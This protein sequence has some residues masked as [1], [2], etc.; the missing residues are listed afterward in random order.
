[1]QSGSPIEEG[2]ANAFGEEDSRFAQTVSGI[3]SAVGTKRSDSA[4]AKPPQ[5]AAD[6]LDGNGT[7]GSTGGSALRNPKVLGIAAVVAVA[8][9]AGVFWMSSGSEETA[10]DIE[11]LTGT[12][13][14]TEADFDFGSEA[15][16]EPAADIA[17][18]LGE[19]RLAREAGQ[20]FNPVGSNAIELY[21]AAVA[22]DPANDDAIMEF[23]ATIEEALG[24]AETALLEARLD[25]AD[26]ALQRVALVD[27]QN[28][29]LP[30]LT[31][32]L[33]QQQLRTYLA[34]ARAAIRNSRFE[35][36]GNLIAAARALGVGDAGEIDV[37]NEELRTA[38]SDQQVDEVL[39][40]A[41]ARLEEGNL[42]SPA[43]DNARYYYELVLSNDAQNAAARQ[44]LTVVASK[45]VLQARTEIDN[46][47]L[48]A[49][50]VLLDDASALD[51][52]STELTATAS[53][54]ASARDEVVA[55][56]RR[57][58]Q[59]RR[60]AEAEQRAA[61]ERRAAEE[62]AEA[63]RLADEARAAAA[64]AEAALESD[65]AVATRTEDAAGETE[66]SSSEAAAAAAATESK[67]VDVRD[68][69]P[70]NISALTRT[71]YVAPKFPR[72]AQRRNQTGWVDVVFTVGL[73]GTVRDVDVRDSEPGDTF[74]SAAIKAVEKWEFQPVSENGV[75]V[76]KRVGV[77][78][79][80]AL[81]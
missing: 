73:D 28:A 8:V 60:Q 67:P 21:A 5:S 14:I 36:A 56:Q 4:E 40:L 6:F 62:R 19:A 30:F 7:G 55:Q 24:M 46:G 16:D 1:M 15:D 39:A 50:D 65:D 23:E 54:L 76:E 41:T 11:P 12:P 71:R 22:A 61:A 75:L 64:E 25:D 44:G 70:T 10:P 33:L 47:N 77:R 79:M 42:V 58:D 81:E 13:S 53:A 3:L 31:A 17:A 59:A 72:A 18:L 27:P 49:A 52:S 35:D 51:P 20:V 38:K 57:A 80:F 43:N 78:M 68:Q 48:D 69:N 32:Q 34:D 66:D 74:V 2:L 9:V 63:E 37:V 26:A 29:R 45:L